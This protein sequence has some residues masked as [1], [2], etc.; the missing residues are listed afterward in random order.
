MKR[1]NNFMK[2][3]KIKELDD[4]DLQLRYYLGGLK[5]IGT[6]EHLCTYWACDLNCSCDAVEDDDSFKAIK[7]FRDNHNFTNERVIKL[8]YNYLIGSIMKYKDF[9]T[10]LFMELDNVIKPYNFI[11]NDIGKVSDIGYKEKELETA[12]YSDSNLNVAQINYKYN[13]TKEDFI[14]LAKTYI[15]DAFHGLCLSNPQDIFMYELKTIINSFNLDISKRNL[16]AYREAYNDTKLNTE[17]LVSTKDAQI[18]YLDFMKKLIEKEPNLAIELLR[19]EL[20]ELGFKTK[21]DI[22]KLTDKKV[23]YK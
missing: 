10:P 12:V 21:K 18:K 17:L 16:E 23:L 11:Q 1:K 22:K 5:S 13:I 9:Y 8:I 19:N 15:N 7:E 2:K 4:K 3:T 14:A 20:N 6:E